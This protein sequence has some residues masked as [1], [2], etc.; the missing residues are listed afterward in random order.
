[1][2]KIDM[3]YLWCKAVLLLRVN[4][5]HRSHDPAVLPRH[6]ILAEGKYHEVI[7]SLHVVP[8][9]EVQQGALRFCINDAILTISMDFE[10][11]AWLHDVYG[12]LFYTWHL[13]DVLRQEGVGC[14][15][16]FLVQRG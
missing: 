7:I 12:L 5:D 6:P 3:V 4:P 1:M 11:D 8:S 2:E 9:D 10:I 16:L 14:G 13:R 15:R